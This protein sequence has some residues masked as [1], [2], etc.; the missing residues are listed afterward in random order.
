M[1]S[2]TQ[3]AAYQIRESKRARRIKLQ[4]NAYD[5]LVVVV[6]EGVRHEEVDVLVRAQSQWIN[7]NLNKLSERKNY[8][9]RKFGAGLPGTI[10]LPAI[11]RS[12]KI[13][14]CQQTGKRG[15]N[16][17]AFD[18][19][20]VYGSPVKAQKNIEGWL[21]TVARE[22]LQARILQLGNETG[23]T[24]KRMQIR[25]QKSRWGSCSS[26]GT[27]SLNRNILFFTPDIVRYLL[28]HELCHIKYL[29]H[30]KE[31]WSLVEKYCPDYKVADKILSEAWRFLPPWAVNKFAVK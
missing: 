17:S 19:L 27:I 9:T 1:N 3:I 12:W 21:T 24:C 22:H 15:W 30:S 5:G 7:H 11:E 26:R 6:P 14:Y 2:V 4:I 28:V 16:Y 20:D 25:A 18:S 13:N 8:L 31:Y 23:L 10:T 29:N